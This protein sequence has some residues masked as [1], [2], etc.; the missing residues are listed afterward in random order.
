[1]PA[2]QVGVA[3]HRQVQEGLGDWVH[4]ISV[5]HRGQIQALR[6]FSWLR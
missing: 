3:V 2:A 5:T 4:M 6:T 1:M